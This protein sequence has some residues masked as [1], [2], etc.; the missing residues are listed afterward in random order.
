MMVITVKSSSMNRVRRSST[1]WS[2]LTQNAEITQ[3][4]RPAICACNVSYEKPHVNLYLIQT[5]N[6]SIAKSK[7]RKRHYNDRFDR[8]LAKVRQLIVV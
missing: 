5:L 4:A 3:A 7:E 2:A 6:V 1:A 8:Y